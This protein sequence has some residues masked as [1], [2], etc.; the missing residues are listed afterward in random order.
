MDVGEKLALTRQ[1]ASQFMSTLENVVL[2]GDLYY[3][4]SEK[5]KHVTK[6]VANQ[7]ENRK[8]F[9]RPQQNN[10][11]RYNPTF[12]RNNMTLNN[13]LPPHRPLVP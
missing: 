2:R 9:F 8:Q 6:L 1:E 4:C 13:S 12:G 3:T 11:N 5:S 7:F 10:F